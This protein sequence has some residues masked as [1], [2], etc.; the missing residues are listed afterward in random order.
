M[1]KILVIS[2]VLSSLAFGQNDGLVKTTQTGL[3][4]QKATIP[5][6]LEMDFGHFG[7]KEKSLKIL[8]KMELLTLKT[9]V[10]TMVFGIPQ[11]QLLWT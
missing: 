7:M 4:K 5:K 11:K 9:R 1:R 8:E 6:V 2:L 3:L 10:K